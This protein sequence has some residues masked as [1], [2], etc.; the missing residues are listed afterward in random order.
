MFKHNHIAPYGIGATTLLGA[1]EILEVVDECEVQLLQRYICTTIGVLQELLDV[2]A[3]GAVTGV[4]GF[5]T[6]VSYFLLELD[7]MLLEKFDECFLLHSDTEIGIFEFGG[8]DISVTTHQL[9]IVAVH[10]HSDSVNSCIDFLC[11]EAL[12]RSTTIL[13]IPQTG[14]N[15]HLATELLYFAI[16]GKTAHQRKIS[17]RL[18][19]AFLHIEENLKCTSHTH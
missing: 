11:F 8:C 12:A 2:V 10:I 1:E 18:L 7:I 19:A 6:A 14:W 15:I 9:L 5:S 13:D 17:V 3:Y 4:G 16:N